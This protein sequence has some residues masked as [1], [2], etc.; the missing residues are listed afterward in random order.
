[1]SVMIGLNSSLKTSRNGHGSTIAGFDFLLG[2]LAFFTPALA[3]ETAA[4]TVKNRDRGFGLVR[5][6]ISLGND[7]AAVYTQAGLAGGVAAAVSLE[8]LSTQW[9]RFAIDETERFWI[10]RRCDRRP[11][12]A[13]TE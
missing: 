2:A 12:S 1:M 5:R 8:T 11:S 6:A 3:T 7:G 4:T 10:K 13:A 9:F